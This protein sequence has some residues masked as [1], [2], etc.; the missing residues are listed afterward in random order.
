[1]GRLGADLPLRTVFEAVEGKPVQVIQ[2]PS[3]VPF[4]FT[5]LTHLPE[6]ERFEAAR[7]IAAEESSRPFDLTRGPLFRARL[8]ELERGD[9]TCKPGPEAKRPL[10]DPAQ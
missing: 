9:K 4:P 8:V 7:A 2:A 5:S 1:M 10:T 6:G 3:E